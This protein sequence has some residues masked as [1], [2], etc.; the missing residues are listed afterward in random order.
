MRKAAVRSL[1]A[2][3]CRITGIL[4]ARERAA[5]TQLTIL[6]YHRILPTVEKAAYFCPDLVVTP[7]AFR[8]H[9][10][11]LAEYYQVLPLTEAV[12]A[13]RSGP[14]P[15][16]L[17]ALTFDDGYVDNLQ[18]AAPILADFGQRATFFVVSGLMGSTT[19]PWY[20]VVARCVQELA[21]RGEGCSA[22]GGRTSSMDGLGPVE[23]VA[24]AKTLL[25]GARQDLV[26]T[27][28]ARLDGLPVSLSQDRI[29][30]VAQL[31]ELTAF[32]HEIGSHSVHHEILPSLDDDALESEIRDSKKQL[33][34]ALGHSV[35]A[36]C[37]PN[38]DYDARTLNM[39]ETC[40]YTMA[41]TTRPG[42]NGPDGAPFA[43]RRRFMHEGRLSD[44]HGRTSATLLR[45]EVSGLGDFLRW[46][47]IRREESR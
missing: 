21:A 23:V 15:K 18:Y 3:T 27:L 41:V 10:R 43:L 28:R 46:R 31:H 38:G 34:D 40:G 7:K 17:V 37:Y 1:L 9:C 11:I 47:R 42:S 25:P 19:P 22:Q 36:F 33:E 4:G 24:G 6:C 13:L 12:N 29:M 39:V 5:R 26:D 45:A 2:Q 44:R 30:N 32:G 20:D 8:H 16:P 35:T 14:H